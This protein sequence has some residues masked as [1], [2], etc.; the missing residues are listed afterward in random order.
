MRVII[1]LDPEDRF[2]DE[3]RVDTEIWLGNSG[4]HG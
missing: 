3:V 2:R 4:R 1:T